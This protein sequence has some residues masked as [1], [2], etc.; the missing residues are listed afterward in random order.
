MINS[1][2]QLKIQWGVPYS[3]QEYPVE[4]Y[5]IQ[6]VNMSSGHVLE[7]LLEYIETSYVYTFNDDVQYC[8]ILTVNVTAISAVGQSVPASVSKGFP[9]GEI[10]LINNLVILQ[11]NLLLHTNPHAALQPFQSDVIV[12]V[13]FSS[14]RTPMAKIS[15]MVCKYY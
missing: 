14:D 10:S 11:Y 12:I 7:S 4:S 1:S 6:I 8:Q 13:I 5:N 9:I 2:S 15:F 3:H